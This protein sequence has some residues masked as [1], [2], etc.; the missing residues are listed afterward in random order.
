[1]SESGFFSAAWHRLNPTTTEPTSRP[2]FENDPLENDAL[3]HNTAAASGEG[4]DQTTP[5]S[6]LRGGLTQWTLRGTD[7][8]EDVALCEQAGLASI[9]L[10]LTKVD[11]FGRARAIERMRDSS[12]VVSSLDWVCNFNGYAGY[13]WDE[14][15]DEALRTIRLAGRLGA[16]TVT[17]VT[18]PSGSHTPTHR[19]RNVAEALAQLAPVAADCDVDLA[20]M[21]MTPACRDD[22][23]FLHT[24]PETVALLERVDHPNVG[25]LF[26]AW[27]LLQQPGSPSYIEQA[28]SWVKLV[29]LSDWDP[30]CRDENDQRFPGEGCLPLRGLVNTLHRHG[31]AG[32]YEVDVW[33]PQTWGRERPGMVADA[34][35]FLGSHRSLPPCSRRATSSSS[36]GR[37]H[38]Q[39]VLHSV[40]R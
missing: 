10:S 34:R 29:R 7:L 2:L 14:Q 31:F 20:V 17:V 39:T 25:L 32:Y 38:P 19:L 1:M 3:E 4:D 6:T 30:S 11:E 18:G 26:H 33:S 24:I 8:G 13:S 9:G 37:P 27:H 23:T 35:R 28:A 40:G 21:P 36:P 22:W 12:L 15:F 16:R 5:Q